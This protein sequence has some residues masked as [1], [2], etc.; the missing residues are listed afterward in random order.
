LS[1][2][3]KHGKKLFTKQPKNIKVQLYVKYLSPTDDLINKKVDSMTIFKW[4]K[5]ESNKKTSA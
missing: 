1:T 3:C 4:K 2:A 5:K